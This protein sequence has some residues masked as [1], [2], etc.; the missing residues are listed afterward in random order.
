M[1]TTRSWSVALGF[2]VCIGVVGLARLRSANASG[3]FDCT[4]IA[5]WVKPASANGYATGARVTHKVN[6]SDAHYHG[7]EC[8]S[9]PCWGDP[10][11]T[12]GWK[13]LGVCKSGTDPR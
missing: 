1:I 10:N 8:T 3:E 4:N 13:D 5:K 7:F 12:S 2:V 9:G 6:G 11:N